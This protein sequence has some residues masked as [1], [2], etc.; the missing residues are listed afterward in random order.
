M[1]MVHSPQPSRTCSG[2][3]LLF[4]IINYWTKQYGICCCSTPCFVNVNMCVTPQ[5]ELLTHCC[6]REAVGTRKYYSRKRKTISNSI[7]L[8]IMSYPHPRADT[9]CSRINEVKRSRLAFILTFVLLFSGS[10]RAC[11]ANQ[12]HKV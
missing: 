12:V 1:R 8:A 11:D 10:A 6:R 3:H 7:L 5:V 9:V 2:S 4:R